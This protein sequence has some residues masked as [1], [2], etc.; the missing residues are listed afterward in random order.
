MPPNPKRR[1][2][3]DYAPTTRP[4]AMREG[5][6]RRLTPNYPDPSDVLIKYTKLTA[7]APGFRAA[8]GNTVQSN[9]SIVITK[10]SG[11][12]QHDLLVASIASDQTGTVTAP[13]GWNLIRDTQGSG[14]RLLVYWKAATASEPAN[15]TW[16]H[17]TT[18]D[19]SAGIAAYKGIATDT[20]VDIE[21][22][23]TTASSTTH[24]TPDVTTTVDC[25]IIASHASADAGI[26][27]P[28][29]GMAE[30]VD[31]GAG[32]EEVNLEISDVAL[33][34]PGATG[35]KTATSAQTATG[36]THIMGIRVSPATQALVTPTTGRRLRLIRLKLVQSTTDGEHFFEVYYGTLSTALLADAGSGAGVVDILD[37]ADK[38]EDLTRSWSRGEGPRGIKNEVLGVRP[39][40]EIATTHDAIIEYTEER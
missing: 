34:T 9:N 39:I 26:W 22:G 15:Y 25:F 36:V 40:T 17:A 6:Q 16:T 37:V 5:G 29:S 23:Q 20:P 30:R 24:A 1:E 7:V 31:E 21:N 3:S 2:R 28:P 38:G 33:V 35:T 19:M 11:V 4:R 13:T 27:T 8:A 10:P 14:V 12:V 32:A 18:G